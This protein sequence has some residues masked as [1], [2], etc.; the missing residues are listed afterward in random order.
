MCAS[1]SEIPLLLVYGSEATVLPIE[2]EVFK[3]EDLFYSILKKIDEGIPGH[4]IRKSSLKKL[5]LEI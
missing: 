3:K 5:R 2:N 1:T 4:S